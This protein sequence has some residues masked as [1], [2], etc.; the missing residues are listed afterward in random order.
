MPVVLVENSGRCN[1]NDS[2]EKVGYLI[3]WIF[4]SLHYLYLFHSFILLSLI[5]RTYT[6]WF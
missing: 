4:D 2:D 3:H 6:S 5:E 1:K